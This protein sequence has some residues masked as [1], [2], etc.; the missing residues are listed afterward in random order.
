MRAT[1][2]QRPPLQCCK[3]QSVPPATGP[4]IISYRQPLL[5]H[6]LV[7]PRPLAKTPL[8]TSTPC[9]VSIVKQQVWKATWLVLQAPAVDNS[10]RCMQ[11]SPPNSHA[12]TCVPCVHIIVAEASLCP[13][14]CVAR[15]SIH[16][17]GICHKPQATTKVCDIVLLLMVLLDFQHGMCHIR[18]GHLGNSSHLNFVCA[19][20]RKFSH[21]SPSST[22][23]VLYLMLLHHVKILSQRVT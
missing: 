22:L 2:W 12:P 14:C 6:T 11:L 7:K 15:I 20:I 8:L 3:P 19:C 21:G 18:Q 10:N 9:R 16:F 1:P 13:A 4:C 23:Q 5:L 17:S